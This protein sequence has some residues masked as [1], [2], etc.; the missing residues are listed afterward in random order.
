ML[1]GNH[2]AVPRKLDV[3]LHYHDRSLGT[4]MSLDA[5]RML[6]RDDLETGLTFISLLLFRNELKSDTRIAIENLR[7]GEVSL[8]MR[9][10]TPLSGKSISI[11]SLSSFLNTFGNSVIYRFHS[12]QVNYRSI[13]GSLISSYD[14][15]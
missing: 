2:S 4:D 7:E 15:H 6:S 13:F 11:I 10:T 5:I 9:R 12:V 1:S 14:I 3:Q 8:I